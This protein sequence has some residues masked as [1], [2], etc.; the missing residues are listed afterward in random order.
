MCELSKFFIDAITNTQII[1]AESTTTGSSQLPQLAQLVEYMIAPPLRFNTQVILW[2]NLRV[3][4]LAYGRNDLFAIYLRCT[5]EELY[6]TSL[7]CR[8]GVF[9]LEKQI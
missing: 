6:L 1:L 2:S 5:L 7:D 9:H 4:T 8:C 3:L